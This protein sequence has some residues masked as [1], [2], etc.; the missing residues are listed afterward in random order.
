MLSIKDKGMASHRRTIYDGVT[1]VVIRTT[2]L[3]TI[4]LS[5]LHYTRHKFNVCTI[6]NS[7]ISVT[8]KSDRSFID[9]KQS[10]A[11]D[12]VVFNLTQM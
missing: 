7:E 2:A 1:Q 5:W 6:Y 10:G 11:A 3:L 12:R 9:F 4:I 8:M